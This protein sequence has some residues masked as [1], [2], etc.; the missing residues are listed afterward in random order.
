MPLYESPV[1]DAEIYLTGDH[2]S[3][4]VNQGECVLHMG[5][6]AARAVINLLVAAIS[7]LANVDSGESIA[8]DHGNSTV[9][10]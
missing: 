5:A 8:T 3:L 4:Y 10:G 1:N 9:G 2:I 7:R 6:A